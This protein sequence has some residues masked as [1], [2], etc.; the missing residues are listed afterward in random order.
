MKN[1]RLVFVAAA[2]QYTILILFIGSYFGLNLPFSEL[3]GKL[4]KNLVI[5]IPIGILLA[6]LNSRSKATHQP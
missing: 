2:I 3:I 5:A 4:I 1:N 6:Y